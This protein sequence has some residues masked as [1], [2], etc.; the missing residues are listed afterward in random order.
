MSET[1]PKLTRFTTS[2]ERENIVGIDLDPVDVDHYMDIVRKGLVEAASAA[3]AA[4][5]DNFGLRA[6]VSIRLSRP[7][8][9]G[10]DV[11][12][13]VGRHTA[14]GRIKARK[15]YIDPEKAPKVD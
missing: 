2:E 3:D 14:T 9:E 15:V 4:V 5:Q 10:D 7:V 11:K 12:E 13:V 6:E 8:A 1:Q